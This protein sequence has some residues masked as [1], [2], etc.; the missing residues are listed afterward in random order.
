MSYQR[1]H[2]SRKFFYSVPNLLIIS[3]Q[4]G[5]TY[6]HKT[7]IKI[8]PE[9]DTTNYVEFEY[10][11]RKFS[12]VGVL[13]R[14]VKDG[15]E[16]YISIVYIDQMWLKCEGKKLKQTDFPSNDCEGD[17]IMLFYQA[18]QENNDEQ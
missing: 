14:I 5:N 7:P 2:Y 17:I 12:L 11:P 4:R 13:K 16:S 6:Q 15:N 1:T 8:K 3:I 18:I 9:L 10:L